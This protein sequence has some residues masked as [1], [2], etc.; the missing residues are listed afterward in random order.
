MCVTAPVVAVEDVLVID[1]LFAQF[2]V[3]GVE[4]QQ[5]AVRNEAVQ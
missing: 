5:L 1:E 2:L 3:A 4:V